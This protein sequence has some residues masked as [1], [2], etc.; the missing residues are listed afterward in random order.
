MKADF[1]LQNYKVLTQG[2]G[3]RLYAYVPP[4]MYA[5]VHPRTI[6]NGAT[7]ELFIPSLIEI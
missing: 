6:L 4:P 5:T 2:Q 1:P 7:S 3:E